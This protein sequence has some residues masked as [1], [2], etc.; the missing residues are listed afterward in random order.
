MK[1]KKSKSA[2]EMQNKKQAQK[3]AATEEGFGQK[4]RG[5]G[6]RPWGLSYDSQNGGGPENWALGM[7]GNAKL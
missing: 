4:G 2:E 6:Q 5:W 7:C 1:G 3:V